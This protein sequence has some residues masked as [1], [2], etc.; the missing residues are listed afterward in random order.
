MQE[1]LLDNIVKELASVY[2]NIKAES[3]ILELQNNSFIAND[4][5][6]ENKSSFKR[7][8][9]RDI[10]K[11]KK[12]DSKLL[13]E[14]SRD[15]V[16]DSLPEGFFHKDISNKSDTYHSKRKI[17]KREEKDSRLLF[18]PIENELFNQQVNIDKKEYKLFDNFY[19]SDNDFFLKF[20]NLKDNLDNRYL[21]KLVKLLPYS[22]KIAGNLELTRLCLERILNEKIETV[23]SFKNEEIK[24][25]KDTEI[26]GVNFI[27]KT[28]KTTIGVPFVEFKIG[29]V[30]KSNLKKYY[31]NSEI[32]KF[33][34]IFY[35]Y[36]LPLE[37]QVKTSFFGNKDEKI[38][39]KEDM[40]PIMGVSTNI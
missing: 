30:T 19:D 9:R 14:L 2:E 22:H 24:H 6:V 8:Y 16:Y 7:G 39:L 17:K 38:V 26:L 29:P 27:A 35:S 4:F 3:I 15:G 32:T 37:F 12:S 23:K 10:L 13:L 34:E 31:K 20:W 1:K 28:K 18:S 5:L 11:S 21:L 33:L 36:F 40:P 25:K